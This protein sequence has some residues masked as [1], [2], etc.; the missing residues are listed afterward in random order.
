MKRRLEET[1]VLICGLGLMGGSLGLALG[2]KAGEVMGVDVDA[3]AREM[4]VA[5]G[6]V[7]CARS[8]E[9]AEKLAR[10]AGLV[11]LATPLGAIGDALKG[12]LPH[13]SRDAVITD[14][15]SV[16]GPLIGELW[17]II[18]CG[19]VYVP[20]H[21]IAGSEEMGI[22]GARGHMFEGATWIV[23][24]RG[25]PLV[26][27]MIRST[28]AVEVGMDEETHDELAAHTS[29][30]PLVMASATAEW[31]CRAHRRNPEDFRLLA[32]GGFRDTTRVAAGSPAMG[33]DICI[34]N[35]QRLL[36]LIDG[37]IDSLCRTRELIAAGERGELVSR[38]SKIRE[39]LLKA[40]GY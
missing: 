12:L 29:H 33:A 40:R 11:V 4:A 37:V 38:L 8:P 35:R 3:R 14:V 26:S 16:K 36:P 5:T 25:D 9:E 15:G 10:R 28:G 1:S 23:V 39:E 32:G 31:S 21:P 22:D 27:E 6:A 24:G 30:L 13:L 18:P 34:Y 17:E 7:S 20:G 2:G 19:M